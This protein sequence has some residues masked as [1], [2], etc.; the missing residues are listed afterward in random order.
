MPGRRTKTRTRGGPRRPP[1]STRHRPPRRQNSRPPLDHPQRPPLGTCASAPST[2][3]SRP[4]ACAVSRRARHPFPASRR[5]IHNPGSARTTPSRSSS[6]PCRQ[7]QKV[8]LSK[9]TNSKTSRWCL[10]TLTAVGCTASSAGDVI[11]SWPTPPKGKT[12]MTA[13]TPASSTFSMSL[14]RSCPPHSQDMR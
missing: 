2:A 7:S 9:P 11:P 14:V 8:A 4:S 6:S 12:P 3:S 10:L 5:A 1:P 13:T